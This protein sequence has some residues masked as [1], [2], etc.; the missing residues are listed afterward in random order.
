MHDYTRACLETGYFPNDAAAPA[1]FGEIASILQCL[2]P[3]KDVPYGLRADMKRTVQELLSIGIKGRL[4]KA[5]T[6][7]PRSLG[8]LEPALAG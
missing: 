8:D 3:Q 2:E 7:P 5:P 4:I 6:A 1:V